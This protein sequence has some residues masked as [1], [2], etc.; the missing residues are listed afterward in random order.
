MRRR[1]LLKAGALLP[2]LAAPRI[3]GAQS[4]RILKFIPQADLAVLDPIFTT[5]YVTRNHGYLVFDTLYGQD[6]QYKAQPQMVEGAVT[7]ADG[8]SSKLTLRPGLKFHDGTPVLARDCVASLQRWG[9]RD[10][11]GQALMAV[12]DE[13]TA[14]DDRTISF[15][16]KKPFPLLPDALAKT[17]SDDVPFYPLGQLYQTTAFK[18]ELTGV[19]DGFVLFWNVKRSA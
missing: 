7:D 15:R 1:T 3:A 19:L 8:K 17:G 5:A 2:L 16:L 11:F 18:K 9:T 12:T 10:A 13:L 6:A 4:P 14:A